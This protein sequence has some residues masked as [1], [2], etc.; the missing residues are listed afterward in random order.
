MMMNPRAG[1]WVKASF[2]QIQK[3]VS[4]RLV[5]IAPWVCKL[6]FKVEM[7]L[8]YEDICLSVAASGLCVVLWCCSPALGE[9]EGGSGV[10]QGPH[11]LSIV[12]T[13]F[14]GV[15]RAVNSKDVAKP[16]QS[17]LSMEGLQ[18]GSARTGPLWLD[19]PPPAFTWEFSAP[20]SVP[21]HPELSPWGWEML[22]GRG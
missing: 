13:A 21:G 12:S 4:V 16:S 15:S 2:S 17:S 8:K 1:R 14:S 11:I 22:A 5:R 19:S 20:C 9:Q 10:W 7:Q 18:E 3:V 6:L